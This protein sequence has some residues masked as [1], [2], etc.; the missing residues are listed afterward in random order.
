MPYPKF[1]NLR[2]LID[3]YHWYTVNGIPELAS[4]CAEAIKLILDEESEQWKA[5]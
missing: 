1:S 3:A 2:Q 5:G 4:L